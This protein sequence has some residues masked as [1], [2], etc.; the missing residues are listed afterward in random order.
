[1]VVLVAGND[2]VDGDA[3]RE[4]TAARLRRSSGSGKTTTTCVEEANPMACLSC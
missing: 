1:M 4:W 3:A 2:V